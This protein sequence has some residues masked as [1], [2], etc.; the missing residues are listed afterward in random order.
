MRNQL[1]TLSPL[2]ELQPSPN[3]NLS[4]AFDRLGL[5]QEKFRDT[6]KFFDIVTW[7]IPLEELLNTDPKADDIKDFLNGVRESVTDHLPVLRGFTSQTK[8]K[9]VSRAALKI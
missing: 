9:L 4:S 7:N 5:V 3:D 6:D 2:P 1:K 8:I